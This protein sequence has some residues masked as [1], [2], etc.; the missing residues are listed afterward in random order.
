[1]KANVLL[2]KIDKDSDTKDYINAIKNYNMALDNAKMGREDLAMVYLYKAVEQNPNY[3]KAYNLLGL[4]LLKINDNIK[5][6]SYF[7]KAK[8]IDN[9]NFYTNRLMEYVVKKTGIKEVKERRIENVYSI[10]KLDQDDAVIPRKYIK[11]ST[12]QKIMWTIIGI[13]VGV[14]SYA[15]IISPM[16][17]KNI[18]NNSKKDAIRFAEKLNEQN[19]IV[20]DITL[21]NDELQEYYDT[22]SVRLKAYEEQNKLFT[23]QYETLTEINELFENGYIS[24]AAKMYVDLDKENITDE[25]LIGLLN[26]A[27][28]NIEG[29]GAKKLCELGTQSWNGGNKTQAISY[30]QLS[31][32]INPDEPETMFL[33]ARLYQNLGR[34]KDAND[35]FDKIIGQHPESNYARRS[36]EARGY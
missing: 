15:T 17:I 3:V 7:L 34:D 16:I 27:R 13:V 21:K 14:L 32:S 30:Y 11:L 6:G 5:A 9:G 26:T 2:E 10:K 33:L 23:T 19:K 12:N 4:L 25:T 28:S 20:R 35:L 8:N 36:R 18:D 1:N 31:L 22:A 29:L 24:K